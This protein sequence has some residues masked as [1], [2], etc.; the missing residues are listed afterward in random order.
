MKKYLLLF[1]M[2][3]VACGFSSL[4]AATTDL[5]FLN[6]DGEEIKDGAVLTMDVVEET[7][8]GS[9]IPLMGIYLKNTTS[10]EANACLSATVSKIPVGS[11]FSC[12]F[13]TFCHTAAEPKTI[14]ISGV[15]LVAGEE[16][17]I[18]NTEWVPAVEGGALVSGTCTVTFQIG[19]GQ[20]D[21]PKI[22][23][24]FVCGTTAIESVQETTSTTPAFN[25]Y[26]QSL[27]SSQKGLRIVNGQKVYSVQ[28]R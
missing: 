11:E 3:F 25:L 26:G 5:V 1:S 12:C 14:Q 18:L 21:G 16:M 4:S 10:A 23:V 28:R 17:E 6:E 27:K 24:N 8:F 22:T 19:N 7:P 13:G 20:A 9:Q 2:L 15:K